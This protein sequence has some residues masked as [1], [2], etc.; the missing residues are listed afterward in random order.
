MTASIS[1]RQMANTPIVEG[2]FTT[3]ADARLIGSRCT[4]CGTYFFPKE[5]AFCRNP[6]CSST[7]LAEVPLS[8]RGRI[9]SF[10]VNRYAP[11][12]PYVSP[13]PFEPYAVAAVELAEERMVVLGQVARGVDFDRLAIG[14]EMEL[15]VERL[16]DE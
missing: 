15:V 9:W 14:A 4:E 5:T 2:W 10:T 13:E 12:P 11:P 1:E 6:H 7:H 3:G 16:D 8:N